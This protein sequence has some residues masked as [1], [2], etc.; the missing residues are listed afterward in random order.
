MGIFVTV[1]VIGF[2]VPVSAAGSTATIKRWPVSFPLN[3]FVVAPDGTVF[4]SSPGV[5]VGR[6]NPSTNEVTTWG[7]R[8]FHL[9]I[10]PAF[11]IEFEG[12]T[13]TEAFTVAVLRLNGQIRLLIPSQ[14][15]SAG[16][17]FPVLPQK[18]SWA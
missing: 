9:A 16:C 3:D 5:L 8:T 17:Q 1:L 4:F 18:M 15:G 12:H 13:Y 10:G 6:L 11:S 14:G 7:L 2:S